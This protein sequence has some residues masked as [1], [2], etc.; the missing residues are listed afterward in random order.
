MTHGKV[1]S[2]STELQ[3]IT[4]CQAAPFHADTVD[5]CSIGTA[6][7]FDNKLTLLANDLRMVPGNL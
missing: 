1:D 6:E 7:I 5:E 2:V 3:L 4:R